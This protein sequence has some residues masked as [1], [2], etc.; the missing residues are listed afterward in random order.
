MID[1]LS[2][3]DMRDIAAIDERAMPSTCTIFYFHTA[4]TATA[5]TKTVGAEQTRNATPA[6]CRLSPKNVVRNQTPSASQVVSP[7]SADLSIAL[8]DWTAMGLTVELTDTIG[9]TTTTR[10]P[11]GT[12]IV[13]TERWNVA[14]EA[15]FGSYS[16]SVTIPVT[17]K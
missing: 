7:V 17:H 2:V 1:L 16:T 5:G 10:N 14:G 12:N 6:R 8:T 13:T 15:S 11:D 4:A 9:V 3:Q